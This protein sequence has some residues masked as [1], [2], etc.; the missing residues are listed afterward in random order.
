MNLC[1]GTGNTTPE[2]V[3]QK[4]YD[5]D[6]DEVKPYFELN[7]VLNN[8]VFYT[9]NR[10]YGITFEERFDLPVY[11]ESVRVWDVL[12]HNGEQIAPVLWRLLRP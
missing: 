11:H 5:I 9:M 7:S 8:G 6:E 2:K 3:R 4:L 12:D 10:L 1:P